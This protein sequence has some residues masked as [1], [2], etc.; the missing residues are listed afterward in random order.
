MKV[1]TK[2]V[3]HLGFIPRCK[4]LVPK[5]KQ[6]VLQFIGFH[7]PSK[8][9]LHFKSFDSY[10]NRPTCSIISIKVASINTRLSKVIFILP[11]DEKNGSD[12]IMEPKI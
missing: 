3:S 4:S 2:K 8:Q 12:I 6:I 10:I 5:H 1:P 7:L 11:L 9:I